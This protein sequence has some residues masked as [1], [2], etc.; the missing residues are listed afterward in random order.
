VTTPK[1]GRGRRVVLPPGLVTELRALRAER[2]AEAL[3][4]GWGEVPPWVFV[5]RTGT[6]LDAGRCSRR[7][8]RVRKEAARHGVGALKLH[9]ARHTWATLALAS[10]KSLRWVAR[11]LGHADPSLTLKVY[12]HALPEEEHDLGFAD[13][14]AVTKRQQASPVLA[15]RPEEAS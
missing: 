3:K 12:S 10:G 4:R 5:S 6:P 15:A 2:S 1:S 11:Q 9:A 14:G 8:D 7:W 13:F